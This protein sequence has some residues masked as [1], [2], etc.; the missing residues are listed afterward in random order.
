MKLNMP[1]SIYSSVVMRD[2]SKWKEVPFFFTF[3]NKILCNSAMSPDNIAQKSTFQEIFFFFFK[4]YWEMQAGISH[5][6]DS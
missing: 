3:L 2:T 6:E 1:Q 5:K 4:D